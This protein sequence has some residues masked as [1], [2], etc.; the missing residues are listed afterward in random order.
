MVCI[1]HRMFFLCIAK[2]ALYAFFSQLIDLLTA[3]CFAELLNN[4]KRKSTRWHQ[5]RIYEN[6]IMCIMA[7]FLSE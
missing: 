1:T 6:M 5:S 7:S 2:H 4:I 3:F